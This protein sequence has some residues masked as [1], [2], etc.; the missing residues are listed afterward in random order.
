MKRRFLWRNARG[1]LRQILM[2]RTFASK[3]GIGAT[4]GLS[5]GLL[6]MLIVGVG[7][8][9][10]HQMSR[11]EADFE[12]IVDVHW[13]SVRLARQAQTYSN[14]NSRLTLQMF[15]SE[16][17]EDIESLALQR[18]RNSEQVSRLIETLRSRV[19]SS[20]EQQLLNRVD[21]TRAPYVESYQ[22]ALHL[23]VVDKKPI[24][25][26]ALIIN[27]TLPRLSQYYAAWNIFV[28]FQGREM[29][30][31]QGQ[32]A[33]DNARARTQAVILIS[34]T[35]IFAVLIALFVTRHTAL[36]LAQRQEAEQAL[37]SAHDELEV[38]IKARTAEL[39][40]LNDDLQKEAAERRLVESALRSSELRYRN[41]VEGASEPIYRISPKGHFTLL[42]S[43]AAALVKL[44]VEKCLGLHYLSLVREDHRSPTQE[45]YAR[46]IRERIPVTDLEFPV[47]VGDGSTIWIGQNVQLVVE[48]NQVVELQGIARDITAR[49][50]IEEQLVESERRYRLLFES[51]PEPMWVFDVTT[52]EF[53]AVNDAAVRH[54][55]YSR[56][57]FLGMTIKDIRPAEDLELLVRQ[58]ATPTGNFGDYPGVWRHRKKDG[59]LIEVE[60][61]WHTLDFDGRAAK[62]VLANDVTERRKS[63]Q[64][65]ASERTLLRTLVDALPDRIFVKDTQSKFLLNNASH[66]K[67]LGAKSQE[68]VLGKTDFDFRPSALAAQ[69]LA[70]EQHVIS[71]GESLINR[72]D[73]TTLASDI[74]R[75]LLV[76]KVALRDPQGAIIGVVGISRDITER[77]LAESNILLQT[78]RFQQLFENAPMGI[79][80]V[81]QNDVV[82]NAN[83]Q[84][85]SMFQ[86]SLEELRG[87]PINETIVPLGC[88]EEGAELSDNTQLGRIVEK[89]TLRQ[90]KDGTL[91]PVKIYGVPIK[92]DDRLVG[93]FA[94]YIDLTEERRLQLERQIVFEIIQGAIS[95]SDLDELFRLIHESIS[96]VL[97]AENCFIALHDPETDL[98]H[99][100]F[101]VDQHDLAPA[102]RPAGAGFS[103][104][105]LREG[106]PLLL[107]EQF[108]NEA[109]Q[110]GLVEKVGTDSA[111]WMSVPLRTASRTIGVLVVQHYELEGVYNEKDLEFLNSVGS[112]VAMAIERK[113][114]EKALNEA[115]QRALSDYERLVERISSL[116]QTLG[117]AREL[118]SIFRA[119]RD[120]AVAS[121]PCDGLAVSLYSPERESRRVVYCWTDHE[122]LALTEAVEAPVG[123]G[124]TGQAIKSGT[125]M[126][127]NRF[128][129]RVEG[130]RKPVLLGPAADNT[131]VRSALT[132][133]MTVMGRTV[134]C[135]EIQCHHPGAFKTEHA[136][137][138]R[139]A[140]NMAAN[141]VENVM[142]IEREQL[143]EEQLRQA[144]KMESIGKLAG[145]IAHDFNNLMTAVTGYSELLLNSLG[146]D[147]SI[148]SKI[149]EIKKAGDR[150]ASLTRQLLAFSRKQMLQPKTLD[151]NDVV[152]G[153]A[154]MLVRVIG[155]DIDLRLELEDTLGKVK[156]DPGQIEQVILN[157]GVNARDAMVELG[158]LTIKTENICVNERIGQNEFAVD[159]GNYVLM[160]V[161]DTGCGMD[162]ETMTLIFEP[163]FTTKEVGKGTG[164]GLST[165][166][167]IVKQ[168]GGHILVDSEVGKG[169]IF[170]VYLPRI[171]QIVGDE[172]TAELAKPVPS[173]EGT[174]LLV[175]DE[176]IVRDLTK[177]ILEY[178][179]YSVLIAANGCEGLQV[180]R[181]FAGRIDLAITDVIMPQMSGREFAKG[182][183]DLRPETGVLYMSGFTDDSIT[184]HGVLEEGVF[185]IQK[186][187][188][189]DGLAIKAREVL[190]R[191]SRGA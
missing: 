103:G 58:R 16:N 24:E 12:K 183:K 32:N 121:V 11:N 31:A 145:G 107:T 84:F 68:E 187:F 119:L 177:E 82:V 117:S 79:L 6:I 99:Y 74:P 38:K 35:I 115:N 185:F 176:E 139:M 146:R 64:T 124:M 96:K 154:K 122:E 108:K 140:A 20:E 156:A 148:R 39:I 116:G 52:L 91:V 18:T 30:D 147:D 66:L 168:S 138:M 75:W 77:K 114:A 120:F 190:D 50:Q 17:P 186:P 40:A 65:L 179:G 41:I 14:Q 102:P 55:G 61:S 141:A 123:N 136:T 159:P 53:L 69:Y 160:S 150:A 51:N 28:E 63:E 135:V 157:L 111:S 171:N 144:Q 34:A 90:R 85:R 7:W 149:E 105:V 80:M 1:K 54:Y 26:R 189:P 137:A 158:G 180:A 57:E 153:M 88:R 42:N 36:R 73:Q 134:G 8:L 129:A 172:R 29:E 2:K 118:T 72:E 60:I 98:M 164:L 3:L 37:Q 10:L 19:R 112:Q 173:G 109:Y 95:T 100:E 104:F 167:G 89:E 126:I 56:E 67:A 174:V 49:K 81:D 182:L 143:Q 78:A 70:D 130:D 169:T 101:W 166:Y 5:F 113:R 127:D 86:F 93:V 128:K 163:F 132:A 151:L 175:E 15:V 83:R 59:S 13:T 4:V 92:A 21:E 110:S 76:N 97:Y 43:T 133:P 184:Y 191:T 125:V 33:R 142:L 27:E 155:E 9:T 161:A 181:D 188:S 106:E 165:V 152:A 23:L 48:N 62:L 87:R 44:P 45:F 170:K 46:Q 94:I 162:A 131:I 22:H 47:I 178:Y 71:S 25:A